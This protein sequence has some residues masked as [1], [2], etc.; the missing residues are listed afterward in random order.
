MFWTQASPADRQSPLEQG[1]G[2]C[3]SALVEAEH[4]Q[5]VKQDGYLRVLRAESLL[6]VTCFGFGVAMESAQ[7][8]G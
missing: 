8:F 4:G 2:F 7:E 5:V 6:P 3:I 1:L